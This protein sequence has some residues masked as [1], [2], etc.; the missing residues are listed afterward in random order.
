MPLA[1]ATAWRDPTRG[2]ELRLEPLDERPDRRHVVR[3]EALLEVA[4]RVAADRRLGERDPVVAPARPGDAGA[5]APG[6]DLDTID[7]GELGLAAEPLDRG[8]QA[9]LETRPRLPAEQLAGERRVGLEDEDLAR[10]GPE[11]GRVLDRLGVDAEQAAGQRERARRST[12]IAPCRAGSSA[13]R[14]V[15]GRGPDEA[16]DRVADVR[17][18]APRIEAA[19]ADLASGRR[20]AGGAS[21]AGPPAPTGAARTC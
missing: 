17:E 21:S 20:A 14:P 15:G 3:R 18:V 13:R 10:V 8:R 12:R 11:A 19:E 2:R 1:Q 16:V 6:S 9:V 7:L 4:R 5:A